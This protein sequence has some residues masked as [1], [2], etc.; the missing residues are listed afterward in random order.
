MTYSGGIR[1]GGL[2]MCGRCGEKGGGSEQRLGVGK[3]LS[4]S[5]AIL[6]RNDVICVQYAQ[7]LGHLRSLDALPGRH[8]RHGLVEL[9]PVC[10][11]GRLA[12]PQ[13]GVDV[14]IV[15]C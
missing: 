4:R 13:R 12:F 15:W 1:K 3:L 6:L 8:A 9:V 5:L 11:W 14:A 10:A 2:W 7:R